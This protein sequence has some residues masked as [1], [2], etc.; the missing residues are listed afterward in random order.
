VSYLNNHLIPL[1]SAHTIGLHAYGGSH[2]RIEL[3]TFQYLTFYHNNICAQKIENINVHTIL[4][5]RM[6]KFDVGEEIKV[7]DKPGWQKEPA[8]LRTGRQVVEVIRTLTVMFLMTT[9]KTGLR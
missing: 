4:R 6:S 8:S 7:L 9:H 2:Y 3:N 5:I 1:I